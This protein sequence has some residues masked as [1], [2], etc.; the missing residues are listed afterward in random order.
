M[1]T[2]GLRTSF[3][4]AGFLVGSSVLAFADEP[5]LV[6]VTTALSSTVISG[7]VNATAGYSQPAQP[8]H[9]PQV[10][11]PTQSQHGGQLQPPTQSRNGWYWVF[12]GQWWPV[13]FG[14]RFIFH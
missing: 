2:R 4:L 9:G 5:K 11:T 8:Q 12:F 7:Y 6:P 14:V 13:Y 10:H 1:K 3:A